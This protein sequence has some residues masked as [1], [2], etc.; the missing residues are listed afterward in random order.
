MAIDTRDKRAS[1]IGIGLPFR[2]LPLPDASVSAEDRLHLAHL[3][4]GIASAAIEG[5]FDE[6]AIESSILWYFQQNVLGVSSINYDEEPF[7]LESAT[8]AL[9]ID[10]LFTDQRVR[11]KNSPFQTNI[12]VTCYCWAKMGANDYRAE[13]MVDAIIA[14][15]GQGAVPVYDYDFPSEPRVGVAILHEP[16][17]RNMTREH[18]Q[19]NLTGGSLWQVVIEGSAE[20]C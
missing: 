19:A 4:R 3:Y 20:Q 10:V 13:E 17:C 9:E 5:I 1:A 18:N 2:V 12:Q 6:E 7:D 14:T 11:R 16:Q 15:V 8:E